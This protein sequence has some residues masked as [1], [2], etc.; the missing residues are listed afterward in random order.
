MIRNGYLFDKICDIENIKFA[1]Y[2]AQKGKKHYKEVKMINAH[3]DKYLIQIQ[4]ML[5][6]RAFRN[7]KYE[8]MTR[9]TDNGKVRE[10]FKLPYFPDRIIHHCILQIVGPLWLKSLIRD[11]YSSIKGRG[12]H[13]G[14]KR[15][16]S[17]LRDLD[18][19]KYCLKMDVKKFYP[20]ID[21]EILKQIVRRKIKDKTIL[22]LLDEI[23]NSTKGVPIGNYLS[24]HFGNLYLSSYDH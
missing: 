4:D 9:K 19:T 12:I 20:S 21:N 13:D 14:V 6:N 16:K 1:H 22:W 24:Q 8:I 23:I 2:N 7:S 17:A 15:I 5:K 11:T 10:I 3:P 18:N